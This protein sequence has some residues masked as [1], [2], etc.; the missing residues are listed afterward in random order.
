MMD[1]ACLLLK[2]W[3]YCFLNFVFLINQMSTKTLNDKS[4]FELVFHS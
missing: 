3:E 2:P 1:Q 4:P